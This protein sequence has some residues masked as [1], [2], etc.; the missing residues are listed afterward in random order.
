MN[1]WIQVANATE[2]SSGNN[3][4]MGILEEICKALHVVSYQKPKE[5]CVSK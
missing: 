3:H 2:I 1:H 5:I 4:L